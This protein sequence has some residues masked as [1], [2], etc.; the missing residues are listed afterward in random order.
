MFIPS[1]DADVPLGYISPGHGATLDNGIEYMYKEYSGKKIIT[2]W[3][4][5][6]KGAKKGKKM[7]TLTHRC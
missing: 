4:Y 2:L 3:C 5:T 6:D 1:K 7:S